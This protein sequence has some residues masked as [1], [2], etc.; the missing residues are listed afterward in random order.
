MRL[1]SW[2]QALGKRGKGSEAGATLRKLLWR[3]L[4]KHLGG[5]KTV[6]ISPDGAPVG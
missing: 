1:A 2:R 4:E 5:A 3:P 6:L